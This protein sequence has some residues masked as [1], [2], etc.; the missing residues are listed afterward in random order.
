MPAESARADGNGAYIHTG[1]PKRHYYVK[2]EQGNMKECCTARAE[3]GVFY[4]NIRQ[5]SRYVKQVVPN[6]E[7]FLLTRTYRKSK[8]NQ[9]FIQMIA[10]VKRADNQDPLP[11][12]VMSYR[13]NNTDPD[14][15]PTFIMG[16]HGNA[17]KPHAGTYYRQDPILTHKVESKLQSGSSCGKAYREM[18]NQAQVN[19]IKNVE[20]Y[21]V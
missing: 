7:V 6:H 21:I 3:N 19:H 2:M 11:Y 8:L 12:Y 17:T 18:L 15:P 13:W 14:F 4:I 10:T 1:S 9:N 16:R 20:E 5:G